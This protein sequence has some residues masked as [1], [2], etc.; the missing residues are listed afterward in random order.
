LKYDLIMCDEELFVK[1]LI[2]SNSITAI[3][4]LLKYKKG[5]FTNDSF[6]RLQLF[7]NTHVV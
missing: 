5:A 4:D 7:L 1:S 3:Q 6:N 2:K